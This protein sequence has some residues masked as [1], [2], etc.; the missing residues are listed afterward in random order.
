[1]KTK[2][3]VKAAQRRQILECEGDWITGNYWIQI[4]LTNSQVRAITRL[5]KRWSIRKSPCA[6][7]ARYL[8]S[9]SLLNM[10]AAET[11]LEALVKYMEDEGFPTLGMYCDRVM[12]M[13]E[14]LAK[15]L[16]RD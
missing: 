5:G 9:V 2:A 15:K 12:Q 1:M 10:E 4:G 3:P 14:R 11:K 16:P 6:T 8:I 7:M 13:R